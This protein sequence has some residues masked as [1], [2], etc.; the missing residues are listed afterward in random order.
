MQPKKTFS[1][2]VEDEEPSKSDKSM[3][4]AMFPGL[5]IPNEKQKKF[6]SDEEKENESGEKQNDTVDDMMAALESMAPSKS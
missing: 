4:A 3:L 1:E 2:H 6:D 5:S